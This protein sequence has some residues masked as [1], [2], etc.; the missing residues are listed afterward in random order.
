MISRSDDYVEYCRETAKHASDAHDLALRGRDKKEVTRLIH[1]RIAEA[2]DLHPGDDLVDIGCGDGSLLRIAGRVGARSAVGLLATEEEVAVLR[3]FG[4]EA[5]Q[6]LTDKLPLPDRSASVIVCNNVLLVVPREKI[7]ASLEEIHR[8]A[9]PG[10]RIFLGEIP[11][12]QPPDPTPYFKTRRETLAYLY[13]EHGLRTWFGMLRRM[14]VW[15]LRG[16]PAVLR[17]GTA[18]SFFATAD[19]FIGMGQAAGL[20]FVRY[21]QHSD[22]NTRNNY[23]FRK[24]G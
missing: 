3:R 1:E 15:A 12:L 19:E 14:I 13:R 6:A 8:I 23:L 21:W 10:A 16:K 24:A 22:P 9:K 20:Q 5:R 2:V 18:T 17:P 7:P 11:F 4:L